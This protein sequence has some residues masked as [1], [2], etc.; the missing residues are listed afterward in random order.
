MLDAVLLVRE[1][2][3]EGLAPE[4]TLSV[5]EWADTN[6][7]LPNTSAEP[8]RWRTD[9]TPYLRGIMDALSTGSPYERV[10]FM[11][12]AQIGGTEAGLNWLGYIIQNAPGMAL[13]VMPTIDMLKRN[14]RTRIDP[15][16]E[17][18]PELA[19][20]IAPTRARDAGNTMFAKS[21]PG[22]QLVMTGANSG[23]GLRSTPARYLFFDEVD[24]FPNDA[25]GDGDPVDLALERA[26]TF[27]GKRKVLMVSTPTVKGESRIEDAYGESDQRRYHVPCPQCGHMHPLEWK[28]IKWPEDRRSEAHAVCPECG[29][30]ID[31]RDKP[32]ML[33][34]GEW[35]ATGDGDGKTA[36]FHLSTLYSPWETWAE[37][38]EYHGKVYRDPSR[39]KVWTNTRLGETW[40]ERGEVLEPEGLFARREDLGDVLP[41]P[42]ALLTCGVDVQPDRVEL[43]VIG[44]GAGEEAWVLEHRVITGDASGQELW[45]ALDAT[46][47]RKWPH[48]RATPDLPIAAVAVD[49]GGANTASAYDFVRA[50]LRRRVWGIK[51]LGGEGKPPWPRQMANTKDKRTPLFMVGVDGLKNVL[52]ARL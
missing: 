1:A 38:A 26:K 21:F 11:K 45:L 37:V 20:R 28:N 27:R 52:S 12:G 31:E 30:V 22:G 3:S 29:G 34:A 33:E 9:R 13:L 15:M 14:T 23:A 4:P 47:T 46:L 35:R 43:T 40:E 8:G 5:S 2:W 39:L 42:V 17:A 16:I 36:G 51:G 6:R 18:T 25:D 50:R 10:V 44:W 41:D 32:A 7:V 49:T 19:K 48:L 24:A